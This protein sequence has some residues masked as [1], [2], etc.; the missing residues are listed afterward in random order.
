MAATLWL[1]ALQLA[2]GDAAVNAFSHALGLI[3]VVVAGRLALPA[4]FV[5]VTAPLTVFSWGLLVTSPLG[6]LINA[7]SLWIAGSRVESASGGLPMLVLVLASLLI[8]ALVEMLISRDTSLPLA[9]NSLICASVLG[10]N[11]LLESRADGR[12]RGRFARLMPT[13]PAGAVVLAGIWFSFFLV[14]RSSNPP[15]VNAHTTSAVVTFVCGALLI[16]FVKRRDVG[17]VSVTRR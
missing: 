4:E 14:S 9:G 2:L 12:Q 8:G 7:G 6:A 10:A 17:I 15:L 1:A 3:P 16:V 5:A 13:R 11:I